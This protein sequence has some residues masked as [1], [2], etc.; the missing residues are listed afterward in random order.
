[1]KVVVA[2]DSF[3]GSLSSLQAGN[4]VK[5]G[6][7]KVYNDANVLV[8]PIADGGEG[9]VDALVKGLNGTLKSVS[10]LNPLGETITASYGLVKNNTAVIEMS[11]AAGITLIPKTK[12]NP[13]KT[14]T[15]GVGEMIKDA[16]NNGSTNFIIGIGG[17]ATNDGGVGMLQALGY[18]FLDKDDNPI[19]FGAEGLS[20]LCKIDDSEALPELKNC[21]FNVA[22]D[23]KN[24]LCGEYGCSKIFS[25]QKGAKV[26]D[27]PIMDGYLLNY[28]NLTKTLYPNSDKDLEGAGAAGGLGFAL[29]SYLNA[30]LTSG[31]NLIL[32]TIEFEKII[33]DA[34]VVV[35]GEGK[36]DKQSAMGKTPFGIASRA[37]KYNI[38]VIAF[39]GAA[40]YDSSY[41][42]KVGIDGI[43][44]ILRGVSTLED[45]MNIENAT[46]N[47]EA[48]AEQVFNFY[49]TI[50]G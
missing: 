28:A 33:A 35:T 8:L 9:T 32:D 27:I 47:A 10:V 26:E 22:C 39:V 37:K 30:K 45:A 40:S 1:M 34:D 24:P 6:I 31:I 4:A 49:K 46:K 44:P 23:V 16:I 5:N 3:K 50:K 7:L 38:P 2:I 36:M 21:T 15:Y 42:N 29:A 19:P 25:P 43:F 11:A 14:T 18:K 41:L 17:S 12:L 13:M 48:T 20:K